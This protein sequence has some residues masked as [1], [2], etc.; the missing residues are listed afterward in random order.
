MLP[1]LMLSSLPETL[2]VVFEPHHVLLRF[3][4]G[5]IFVLEFSIPR[6][7]ADV[8]DF[9]H[10]LPLRVKHDASPL[11]REVPVILPLFHHV[12]VEQ[13]RNGFR[14]LVHADREMRLR[15]SLQ[16]SSC[17]GRDCSIRRWAAFFAG[18]NNC[19]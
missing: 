18:N 12:T 11:A 9:H 4:A 6:R 3:F 7:D 5:R 19:C 14:L 1:S 2:S 8:A 13:E 16:T 15:F 17:A 10:P